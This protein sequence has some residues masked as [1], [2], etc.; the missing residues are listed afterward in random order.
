M[1]HWNKDVHVFNAAL[2]T[3][4]ISFVSTGY[5]TGRIKCLKNTVKPALMTT[6]IKL[7]SNFFLVTTSIKIQSN[8]FLE[9]DDLF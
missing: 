9:S 7:Q 6:S 2:N 1:D 5:I 8:F 3:L 4:K